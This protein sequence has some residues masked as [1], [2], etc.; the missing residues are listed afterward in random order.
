MIPSLV[1]TTPIPK[2]IVVASVV[3]GMEVEEVMVAAA[4]EEGMEVVV[5]LAN[6]AT[7]TT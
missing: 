2:E 5:A 4:E 7:A 6:L 1:G 3:V